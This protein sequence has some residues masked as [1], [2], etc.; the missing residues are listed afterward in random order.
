MTD[1]P[2]KVGGWGFWGDLSNGGD[3]FEMGGGGLI[4]LYR[5]CNCDVVIPILG[6]SVLGSY[7]ASTY[8]D[9]SRS[10]RIKCY[11]FKP[12]LSWETS[13]EQWALGLLSRT[14]YLVDL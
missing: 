13:I 2:L 14:C 5:L 1:L 12:I 4:P 9:V 7:E 10:L 8:K 6:P 11:N 3:N